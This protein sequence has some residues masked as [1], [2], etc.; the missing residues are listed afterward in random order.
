MHKMTSCSFRL[1]WNF[2]EQILQ[3]TKKKKKDDREQMS[4][5]RVE[6]KVG[7]MFL[8][9]KENQQLARKPVG[10]G[11]MPKEVALSQRL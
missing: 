2:S 3:D 9:A 5:Q 7:V 11:G 4:R 10:L 1:C 6:A 8:Q